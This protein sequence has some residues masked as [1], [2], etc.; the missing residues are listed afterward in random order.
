MVQEDKQQSY[1]GQRLQPYIEG[2]AQ[3]GDVNSI[4]LTDPIYLD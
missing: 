2:I 3:N 4:N 1:K